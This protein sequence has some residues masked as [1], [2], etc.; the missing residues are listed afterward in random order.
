MAR[1]LAA[2]IAV[3]C[4]LACVPTASAQTQRAY[5]TLTVNGVD[6]G[7]VLVRVAENDIWAPLGTLTTAGIHGLGG[8]RDVVNG[9]EWVSLASLA[10]AVTFDLDERTLLLRLTASPDL[11]DFTARDLHSGAP[12]D[13]VYRRSSNGFVNYAFN[14]RGRGEFDLFADTGASLAGAF[15]SNTMS[16]INGHTVM[17]G[18]TSATIDEPRRLRR[19]TV[20]DTFATGGP[21]G[22]DVL[23]GGVSVFREFSVQPYFVR[24]PGLSMR[25]AVTTPSTIELYV[26]DR[27]VRRDTVA[28]GRFELA[29]VPMTGGANDA[30]IVI[31]DAFGNV[32]EVSE[33]YYVT[34][35]TLSKGLHDYQY[36]LGLQRRDDGRS[37]AYSRP[38]LIARHRAGISDRVTVGGRME[39]GTSVFSGGPIVNVRLPFAEME[40]AAGASRDRGRWGAAGSLSL[41]HSSRRVSWGTNLQPS[42]AR[43]ATVG[44]IARID[45]PRL[46][47]T[48]FVSGQ[49]GGMS[50]TLQHSRATLH[51]TEALRQR[52]TLLVST[53]LTRGLD[54]IASATRGIES[55]R[56]ANQLFIGVNA[57]MRGA[58]ASLSAERGERGMQSAVELRRPTPAGT[59]YGYALRAREDDRSWTG[60]VEYQGP[61]GRYEIRRDG[62]AGDEQNTL[63]LS[64]GLV[65]VG[66]AVHPSRPVQSSFA[67]IRV[68]GVKGVRA[69]SNH[70][71]VGRTNTRGELLIPDLLPYYGNLL[72]IADE[73][74]PLEY[75]IDQVQM[76]IAPPNRGGALVTFPVTRV[77]SINGSVRL[78]VGGQVVVPAFGTLTIVVEGKGASSPVGAD[79]EFY[80]QNIAA[81]RHHAVVQHA[82]MSCEFDLVIPASSSRVT[83][84][85]PQ[86]CTVAEP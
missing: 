49:V 45:R 54:L 15:V 48:G 47:A 33:S 69:Y 21:L 9:E 7:E 60:S 65:V 30:R 4:W 43:Y 2:G 40:A 68:P 77:Q 51:Q 37:T 52:T 5:L 14:W 79:G 35:S 64:G 62:R 50:L 82:G 85:A 59:G 6:K 80:F 8:R 53:R 23:V 22:G 28:P 46:E 72:R 10:P 83:T 20:G 27:L 67:L 78:A 32:R 17:R 34:T 76:T 71:E 84:L 73:D 66:G 57:L 12:P 24:Y 74:I 26:N 3:V 11:L 44:P 63:G 70:Q 1:P 29:N 38:V 39:S 31:K 81:G 36:T 41:T 58:T 75:E 19:W 13:L 86:T 42:S 16:V 61:F 56:G 18:L 25:G 55:G